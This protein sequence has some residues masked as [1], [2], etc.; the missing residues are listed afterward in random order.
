MNGLL[1][2]Y[3]TLADSVK[4]HSERVSACAVIMSKYAM[5]V[6]Q[7]EYELS[8]EELTGAVRVGCLYHDIGKLFYPPM[9]IVSNAAE[10]HENNAARLRSHTLDGHRKIEKYGKPLFGKDGPYIRVV[11]DIVRC[12]H[13]WCDGSG[14]PLGLCSKDIPSAASLCAVVNEFDRLY[15]AYVVKGNDNFE[16]VEAL[17]QSQIGRCFTPQAVG[18]FDAAR[19]ELATFYAAQYQ[20]IGCLQ[21]S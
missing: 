12:H 15:S 7:A 19:D 11:E 8:A 4:Q 5:P 16:F 13:E 10:A 18:W 1:K 17:T 20:K 21:C 2:L 14:Q 9:V 3:N 6:M